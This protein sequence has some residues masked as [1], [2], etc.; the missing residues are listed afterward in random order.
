[1]YEERRIMWDCRFLWE[2]Q[3]R[4]LGHAT[5]AHV[6]VRDVVA[7]QA[8]GFQRPLASDLPCRL[9]ELLLPDDGACGMF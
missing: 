2:S 6:L 9:A 1:M 3:L 8:I 7:P 4:K 5:C